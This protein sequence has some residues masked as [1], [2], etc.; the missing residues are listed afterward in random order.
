MPTITSGTIPK[1]LWPGV[2][3]FWGQNYNEQDLQYTQ[4]FETVKSEKHREEMQEVTDF[5]FAKVKGEGKPVEYDT[6]YNGQTNITYHTEFALGFQVTRAEM[7]DNLYPE[8]SRNRTGKLA[9]SMMA[10]KEVVCAALFNNAFSSSNPLGDGQPMI[11]T[12]HP[13]IAGNFSNQQATNAQFSEAAMESLFIQMR[14]AKNAR[15]RLIKVMPQ[16]LVV[17]PQLQFAA[18][19]LLT[20]TGRVFDGTTVYRNDTNA[21]KDM[22]MLPKGYFV[23]NYL[24]NSKS[25]FVKTSV[26]KAGLTYYDRIPTEI[27][28]DNDF[29][30]DNAKFKAYMRFSVTNGDPRSVYGS[31]GL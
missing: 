10:T 18:Q 3:A 21:I 13:T 17:P 23:W 29:E 27:S 14:L 31:Q 1:A 2:R 5:G 4:V 22:G 24:T 11:S 15:G 7:D 30:T 20:S 12:A 6:I 16:Q 25:W 26:A 28:Q 8:L 19:R 9:D